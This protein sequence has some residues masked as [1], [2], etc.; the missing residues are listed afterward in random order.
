MSSLWWNWLGTCLKTRK[1]GIINIFQMEARIYSEV[2][3]MIF[4]VSYEN[5]DEDFS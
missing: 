1:S 2:A 3:R 4:S 5:I